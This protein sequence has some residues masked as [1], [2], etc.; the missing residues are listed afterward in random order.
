MDAMS[1]IDFNGINDVYMHIYVYIHMELDSLWTLLPVQ[2][3]SEF[4][5]ESTK[6]ITGS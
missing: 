5:G 1:F 2:D 4:G 6:L 3:S